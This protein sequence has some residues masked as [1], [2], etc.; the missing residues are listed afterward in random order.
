MPN[1]F[2][3]HEK[4]YIPL[5]ICMNACYWCMH[6]ACVYAVTIGMRVYREGEPCWYLWYSYA[7]LVLMAFLRASGINGIPTRVQ[8]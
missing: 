6:F 5:G 1:N 2:T 4:T 8:Y 3:R 7:R